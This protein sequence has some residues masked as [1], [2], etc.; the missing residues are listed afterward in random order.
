MGKRT[1]GTPCDAGRMDVRKL[2][3]AKKE[4]QASGLKGNQSPTK[5]TKK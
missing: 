3:T 1:E 4:T 2:E 5:K